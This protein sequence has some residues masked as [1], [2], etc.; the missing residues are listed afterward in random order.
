MRVI[1]VGLP[2]SGKTTMLHTIIRS[3]P[4][5]TFPLILDGYETVL[6]AIGINFPIGT[7]FIITT[8]NLNNIPQHIKQDS[9]ILDIALLR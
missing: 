5:T 6:G 2:Q 8:T 1:I 9:L 4:N 7:S 3:N